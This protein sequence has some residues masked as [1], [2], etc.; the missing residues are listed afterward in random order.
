MRKNVVITIIISIICSISFA[1]LGTDLNTLEEKRNTLTNQMENA[2]SVLNDVQV[3]ISETMKELQ[4]LDSKIQGYEE[5][6]ENLNKESTELTETIADLEDKLVTSEESY[7]KQREMSQTRLI[8]AYEAGETSYL[9]ILLG[10]NS[11]SD[12]I[13]SYYLLSEVTRLDVEELEYL[14]R[15]KNELEANKKS[16]ESQKEKL[17]STKN[18]KER[19]AIVL[20]NTKV[21]RSKY[22]ASLTEDEKEL[23]AKIEEYEK[24]LKQVEEEILL[25][26]TANLGNGYEGGIM[27]WPVP[28][29][30]RITS[31]FAMRLHP[32][33]H[34][35]KLHTGIDIGAPL[36]ANFVAASDGVVIKAGLNGAYGKMV[37]IDH[38]GGITTLYAHGS[39]ILVTVGQQVKRGE[40]VLKVG[41]T[42]YSTGPHAHFEVRVN[43]E[44]VQPLDY[45][46]NNTNK[47]EETDK[48]QNGGKNE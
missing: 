14:E 34:V 5:E 35:Y 3:E 46:L 43:G 12:F 4:D 44:Y 17:K 13:S 24:E 8:A 6:I 45:L 42:G 39:E 7:N 48:T 28:G 30:T 29:Y 37:I 11:I 1:V 21:L 10:S 33:L 16:L 9:D 15:T 26:T 40:P 2:N 18:N 47:T 19:T 36:G 23:Q 31:E 20:E 27:A 22:V 41:S 38:G 25:L 32:I